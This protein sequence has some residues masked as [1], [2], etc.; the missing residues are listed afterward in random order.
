MRKVSCIISAYNEGPRIANV[1]R[2]VVGHPLIKEVIVVD[3]GS[4]DDTSK[5]VLGF[6][7]VKLIGDKQN[8]GKSHSMLE[9]C[10]KAKSDLVM[11]IDADLVGLTKDNITNLIEP[12]SKGLVDMTMSM[13]KNTI[14]IYKLLGH[15]F[16]SGERVMKRETAKKILKKVFGFGAEVRINQYFLQNKLKF[17]VIKW[18]NVAETIKEKKVGLLRGVIKDIMMC[19]QIFSALPFYL[20]FKQM[21]I[22]GWLS[23][24]YKKELDLL[25]IKKNDGKVLKYKPKLY[26]NGFITKIVRISIPIILLFLKTKVEKIDSNL[27]KRQPLLIA[28]HHEDPVDQFVV[29][30]CIKRKLFWIADTEPIGRSLADVRFKKWFMKKIGVI[31]IDKKNPKRN[32]NLFDYLI[33]ILSKDNAIVFFP[34]AYLSSERN[35]Q[36]FGEFKDGIIRLA[37]EYRKRFN[38][39]IP[40]YP[41]GIR[42]EK[43]KNTKRA[44]LNIGKKILVKRRSDRTKVFDAIK[45]LS[46]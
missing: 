10:N 16:I 38:K 22:M 32:K 39:D 26:Y 37:L 15:D 17:M 5:I 35:N 20:V 24:N 14:L 19:K 8:H 12:V 2:A 40:I 11:F 6:K 18:P 1:L 3:D 23:H 42:Y 28:A 27:P 41:V 36:K 45:K 25:A 21:F 13:R 33:Y 9:G 34:E 4:K 7:D 44:S 30:K 46:F 29:C 31:P 43:Q